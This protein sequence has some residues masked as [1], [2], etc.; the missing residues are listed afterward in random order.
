MVKLAS[1]GDASYLGT[2]LFESTALTQSKSQPAFPGSPAE[3]RVLLKNAGDAPDSFLIT[4]TG[5]GNDVAVGYLDQ[6][7]LNVSTLIT[8]AGYRTRTLAPSESFALSLRVLPTAPTLGA[9]YRV[10]VTAS[11]LSDAA[12]LDQVKT[13]TVAC[14]SS[15]AVTV[16]AP[17]DRFGAPGSVVNY[18]YTVT[19][20]GNTDQ[21][22][23]LS[24]VSTPAWSAAT[25]A[26][27]GSGGGVPADGV[28]QSGENQ[29]TASTGPLAPGASYRFFVSLTIPQSGTDGARAD[30][31]LSVTGLGASGADQVTT[32]IQAAAISVADSVR[33]LTQGGPFAASSRGVPGDILEYRMSVTNSG[34]AA[35][36]LVGID[37]PLP[38]H[39]ALVAGSA[40]IGVAAGG[41]GEHCAPVLC[42]FVRESDAGIVAHLGQGASDSV[43]GALLP[44]NTLYV[45]FR[46]QVQ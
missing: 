45:Y 40:W 9:S 5:S 8:G 12:R 32:S 7:G 1:E 17:A 43:G 46:V 19:N 6:D 14:G 36:S 33:N 31:R 34:S 4:G 22:F 23:T 44:G 27:D 39:T 35:A 20:V 38:V 42:G 11:S 29:T 41:D 30:S 16:S 13:E 2:G 10:A 26:D 37:N 21:S 25:Y 28:R 24:V 3:F 18:P 15:A